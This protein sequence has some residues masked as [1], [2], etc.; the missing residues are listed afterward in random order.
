MIDREQTRQ[1]LESQ[2]LFAPEEIEEA[3][4]WAESYNLDD[5]FIADKPSPFGA[6]GAME[7]IVCAYNGYTDTTR[8]PYT[9]V[10][11]R[12]SFNARVDSI[13]QEGF[14]P[15][16]IEEGTV[17]AINKI[18]SGAIGI[19]EGDYIVAVVNADSCVLVPTSETS[20]EKFEVFKPTLAGFFNPDIHKKTVEPN[21]GP[22]ISE[23]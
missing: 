5:I 10:T 8:W 11:E 19:P 4:D 15:N 2:G 3:L 16:V 12:K 18:I 21:G 22:V 13:L 7:Y 14:D 9:S 17:L 20:K 23:S 6:Q 1:W